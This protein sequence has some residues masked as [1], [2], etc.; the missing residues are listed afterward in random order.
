[1]K[2]IKENFLPIPDAINYEINSQLLVRNKKTGRILTNKKR[3]DKNAVVTTVWS[4]TKEIKRSVETFR[5]QAVAAVSKTIW[6]PIPSLNGLY[7]LTTT[8]KCRNV[9]TK[10]SLKL[11]NNK[12]FIGYGF[13]IKGKQYRRTLKN[14]LWEVFGKTYKQPHCAPVPNIVFLN[15]VT[16]G[17]FDTLADCA[18]FI[19]R[20]TTKNF[21]LLYS[22]LRRRPLTLCGYTIHYKPT[23]DLSTVK[24]DAK[25][26]RR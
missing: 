12:N 4:G 24:Y 18:R 7:E 2:K 25:A 11:I 19:A 15:G 23:K 5:R 6:E 17:N 16:A 13:S 1:M 26:N 8:G 20:K 14:L 10:K 3:I 22:R 9:H 21:S